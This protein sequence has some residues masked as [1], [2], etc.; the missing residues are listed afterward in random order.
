MTTKYNSIKDENSLPLQFRLGE[1]ISTLRLKYSHNPGPLYSYLLAALQFE[2][3]LYEQEKAGVP[4]NMDLA[5]VKRELDKI[6]QMV[7]A[8]SADNRKL[9]EM[10]ECF[11]SELANMARFQG[12]A[13]EPGGR[14]ITDAERQAMQN[15]IDMN[16]NRVTAARLDLATKFRTVVEATLNIQN[17]VLSTYLRGWKEDQELSNIGVRPRHSVSL[18]MIQMWCEQL[19]NIVWDTRMQVRQL[20]HYKNQLT[21]EEPNVIDYLPQV[22]QDLN[23]LLSNLITSTFVIEQQP[24]QVLRTN[25]RFTATVRLLTGNILNIRQNDPK[26][27]VS[28]ESGELETLFFLIF[29]G[30]PTQV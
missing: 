13:G 10:Y 21:I 20:S 17:I 8:N 23:S 22:L 12:L 19:A 3:I 15:S 1:A 2:H 18:D 9:K 7:E 27:K 14:N 25:T 5:N 28:I 29:I 30:I 11:F 26:I 6:S 16:L 24:P 4:Q